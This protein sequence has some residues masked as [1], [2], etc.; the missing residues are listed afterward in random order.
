MLRLVQSATLQA[1]AVFVPEAPVKERPDQLSKDVKG[2]VDA[3]VLFAVYKSWDRAGRWC[4]PEGKL[5]EWRGVRRLND[6]D[7]ITMLNVCN[8]EL[9]GVIPDTIG[10]LTALRALRLDRNRL[11]GAIPPE[12]GCC[13]KLRLLHLGGNA[14]SGAIPPQL[15]QLMSEPK[16]RLR[17]LYLG[18]N[19]LSG[20]LPRPIVAHKRARGYIVDVAT[21]SAEGYVFCGFRLAPLPGGV[22]GFELGAKRDRAP[23]PAEE[24]DFSGC[25]LGARLPEFPHRLLGK[26]K[27]LD[28]HGNR[29]TGEIP[30][31][32]GLLPRLELLR[33][34]DNELGGAMPLTIGLLKQRGCQVVVAGNRGFTLGGDTRDVRAH[35]LARFQLQLDFSALCLSGEL[36]ASL[37]ELE[38]CE[39]SL[40]RN[41]LEGPVPD[42]V[43]QST[44]KVLDLGGNAFTRLPTC[45]GAMRECH[46]LD[47]SENRF[48]RRWPRRR[49]GRVG[50]EAEA[51]LSSL[52]LRFE[53]LPQTLSR[54]TH[55]KLLNVEML[56]VRDPPMDVLA[57]GVTAL[58]AHYTRLEEQTG[59]EEGRRVRIT[60]VGDARAGR[61]SLARTLARGKSTLTRPDAPPARAE[62]ETAAWTIGDASAPV[63]A[64][65]WDVPGAAKHDWGLRLFLEKRSL[66][67]LAFDTARGNEDGAPEAIGEWLELVDRAC[68]EAVVLVVGTNVDLVDPMERQDLMRSASEE[69]RSW[70]RASQLRLVLPPLFTSARTSEGTR[71]VK[72][73][74]EKVLRDKTFFPTIG[75]TIAPVALRCR[76]ML[77]ALR[78]GGG[79]ALAA[80]RHH[81]R[82]GNFFEQPHIVLKDKPRATEF[83]LI[84]MDEL[85]ATWVE[86]CA[87][88]DPKPLNPRKE[89]DDAIVGLEVEGRA[90]R[91]GGVVHLSPKA[92]YGA[93]RSAHEHE[94]LEEYGDEEEF[95][96]KIRMT[97]LRKTDGYRVRARTRALLVFLAWNDPERRIEIIRD[98]D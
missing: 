4:R 45:A 74:V 31:S 36:P 13:K 68:P 62:G 55:L 22:C 18:G 9:S 8:C 77:E 32:L 21:T 71:E 41:G 85:A 76:A 49:R 34:D 23:S 95:E 37:G 52:S 12:L 2:P 92:L 6:R 27:A 11:K 25:C 30:S 89:L 86:A 67:V 97:A 66:F 93:W 64:E 80:A 63:D 40:G 98:D 33:L 39:L 24:L 48:E 28:L 96:H 47:L 58:R 87:D 10:H 91:Y 3:K 16:G 43:C 17:E 44:L 56:P 42:F 84:G 46:T 83:D 14:L 51:P 81:P 50:D 26:L 70:V 19:A 20:E 78:R 65:Y 90:R 15:G 69:A 94:A 75:R 82:F 35:E 57:G 88:I 61:T 53:T 54:L 29:L 59:G 60:L 5:A 79:D 1:Q 38:L 72:K 7:E 73:R